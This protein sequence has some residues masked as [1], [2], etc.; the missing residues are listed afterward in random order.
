VPPFSPKRIQDFVEGDGAAD[1][2][3][4]RA[5]S[6]V[7]QPDCKRG[8]SNKLI[9]DFYLIARRGT[10]NLFVRKSKEMLADEAAR[11]AEA[12]RIA[13]E[14]AAKNKAAKKEAAKATAPSPP[15]S[16]PLV[17]P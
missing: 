13:E 8:A 5:D 9:S 2:L 16:L 15:P 3:I 11:A 14:Q 4:K 12:K 10:A 17:A 6:L 1:K 7:L